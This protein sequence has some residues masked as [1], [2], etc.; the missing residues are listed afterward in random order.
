MSDILR[1][2]ANF[3]KTKKIIK[4]FKK[5]RHIKP[6]LMK[7]LISL[8]ALMLKKQLLGNKYDNHLL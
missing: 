6:G 3:L 2:I 7:T 4:I 8:N 5:L 1:N